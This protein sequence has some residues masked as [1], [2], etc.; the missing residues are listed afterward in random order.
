M[1]FHKN[2]T[3][4]GKSEFVSK[5]TR[6]AR[7]G[8]SN[9]GSEAARPRNPL[10]IAPKMTL[11]LNLIFPRYLGATDRSPL[12]WSHHLRAQQN[13]GELEIDSVKSERPKTATLSER[14]HRHT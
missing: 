8:R 2:H 10:K 6:L 12:Q 3:D 7:G 13:I 14:G 1:V 4:V 5:F 11:K 9:S